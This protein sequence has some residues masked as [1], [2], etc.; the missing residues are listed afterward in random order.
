MWWSSRRTVLLATPYQPVS[1]ITSQRSHG[2][3][4]LTTLFYAFN[5][6]T[7]VLRDMKHSCAQLLHRN[8]DIVRLVLTD[9]HSR[10]Y[11]QH[12]QAFYPP[13]VPGLPTGT[14]SVG[15]PRHRTGDVA[16]PEKR[17]ILATGLCCLLAM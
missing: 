14:V 17:S 13:L 4:V 3:A 8:P 1:G 11:G 6:Y 12:G 7:S 5:G 10:H 16:L 9:D 2:A 15:T